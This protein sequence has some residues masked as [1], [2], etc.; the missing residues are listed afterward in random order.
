MDETTAKGK[1]YGITELEYHVEARRTCAL[2]AIHAA[3]AAACHER[4]VKVLEA[5]VMAAV[6][7]EQEGGKPRYSNAEKR[8]AEVERRLSVDS[9]HSEMRAVAQKC[10]LDARVL[11]VDAQYHADCIAAGIALLN[12]AK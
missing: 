4:D 5:G 12:A 10:A 8:T 9:K 2:E 11:V 6:A 3:D 1:A 7:N